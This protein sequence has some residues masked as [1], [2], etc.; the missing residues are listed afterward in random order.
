MAVYKYFT[1][2]AFRKA[3]AEAVAAGNKKVG[4]TWDGVEFEH[5]VIRFVKEVK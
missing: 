4:Y 1:A 5:F 2:S 3:V